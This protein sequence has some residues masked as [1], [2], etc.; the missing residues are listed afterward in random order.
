M[1]D[2]CDQ[3]QAVKTALEEENANLKQANG[4]LEARVKELTKKEGWALPCY[5][6]F[7]KN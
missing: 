1:D 5:I 4:Q 6:I 2:F 3:E 7:E